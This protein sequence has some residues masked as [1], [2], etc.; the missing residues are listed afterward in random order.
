MMTKN[1][2]EIIHHMR[3]NSREKIT[4]L[5]KMTKIPQS[6]IYEKMRN[7][8]GI[9]LKHTAI[10]DFPK[11]GLDARVFFVLKIQKCD[12]E[13]VRKFLESKYYINNLWKINNG[14]D[15]MFDAVFTCMK[16]VECFKEDLEDFFNIKTL[17][18]FYVIENIRAEDFM[19]QKSHID[20]L[21]KSQDLLE[22]G[23]QERDSEVEHD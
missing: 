14:Y 11:I 3:K 19:S 6:T 10:L 8:G 17:H 4:K 2:L 15:Y 21:R 13:S 18:M 9:F 20:L 23:E 12:K 16:E 7:N 1:D 5:A 22:C